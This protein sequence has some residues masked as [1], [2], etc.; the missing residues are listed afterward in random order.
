MIDCKCDYRNCFSSIHEM[1]D[2]A[3]FTLIVGSCRIRQAWEYTGYRSLWKC[4]CKSPRVKF[5]MQLS[6]LLITTSSLTAFSNL[7]RA[8]ILAVMV[9]A[10]LYNNANREHCFYLPTISYHHCEFIARVYYRRIVASETDDCSYVKCCDR[11]L[12]LHINSFK[13]D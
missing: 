10:R 7:Y 5:Y 8:V 12:W 9:L 3:C 2:L 6:K 1:F 4:K 13:R 11:W